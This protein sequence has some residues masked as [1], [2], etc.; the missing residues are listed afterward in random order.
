MLRHPRS[1]ASSVHM[2]PSSRSGH[3]GESHRGGK[4]SSLSPFNS[5]YGPDVIQVSAPWR[6]LRNT[7]A[8]ITFIAHGSQCSVGAAAPSQRAAGQDA[9]RDS[10]GCM[11]VRGS[12]H[13]VSV[14]TP[15]RIEGS[16]PGRRCTVRPSRPSASR[17]DLDRRPGSQ[18]QMR[19]T[20]VTCV[21][22]VHASEVDFG[23]CALSVDAPLIPELSAHSTHDGRTIARDN[24]NQHVSLT[25]GS[26]ANA[27]QAERGKQRLIEHRS[28]PRVRSGLRIKRDRT[29]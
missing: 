10:L 26:R 15:L 17:G 5:R 27:G 19:V 28:Q 11:P 7:G 9:T 25:E 14:A 13:S 18:Y 16:G 8:R 23:H 24:A 21:T 2:F 20:C 22:C 29:Q 1:S 6:M 3:P 4:C 12:R